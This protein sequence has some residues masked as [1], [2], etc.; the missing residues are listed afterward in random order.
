VTLSL[1]GCGGGRMNC[2]Y[3][4]GGGSWGTQTSRTEWKVNKHFLQGKADTNTPLD[5]PTVPPSE[6][7]LVDGA[8]GGGGF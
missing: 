2:L 7:P 3:E 6:D 4:E 5:S 8:G 1:N